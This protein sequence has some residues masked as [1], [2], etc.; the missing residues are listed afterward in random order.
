MLVG[1]EKRGWEIEVGEAA[2]CAAVGRR[3]GDAAE[4]DQ[5]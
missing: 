1:R 2:V 4:L 5:A 3:S